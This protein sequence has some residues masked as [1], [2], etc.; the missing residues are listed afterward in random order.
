MSRKFTV[1]GG[2]MVGSTIAVELS[3]QYEVTVVDLNELALGKLKR[4][5]GISCI[6]ADVTERKT[7]EKLIK[8]S[9]L[10]IGAVPGHLGYEVIKRVIDIGK[11]MVDISFFPED[12]F[13]LDERAKHNKVAVAIDCGIAPGISNMILGYHAANMKVDKYECLV[14]GLPVIRQWPWEYR[15]VFSP[16]DVIEEYVRPARYVENGH[17]ITKDALSDPELV[18]FKH[19]GTLEAWNSDGLRTLL[20]TMKVPNMIEKTLRYPGTIEYLRVLRESGFFSQTE[21]SVKGLTVRPLDVTTQLLLP[22]WEL[23]KGE[24]DFTVMRSKVM[25]SVGGEP[26]GYEYLIY[27]KFDAKTGIHSM[28]RTT[29]YTCTAVTDIFMDGLVEKHGIIAPEILAGY[30]NLFPRIISSLEAHGIDVSVEK[31]Y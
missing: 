21:I 14:G 2:G 22:L 4:C 24:E 5:F 19:I 23:K 18:E 9:E 27:D 29:G 16:A 11:N 17:Q 31:M 13:D 3:K 12:P 15:A 28:A 1:L 20:K 25:G 30:K 8:D 7:L 10:V 26:A 6:Q